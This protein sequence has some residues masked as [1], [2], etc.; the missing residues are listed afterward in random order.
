MLTI[1]MG[2]LLG[3]LIGAGC[4]WF[5][6]PMPSPPTL[7]GTLLVVARTVG[8]TFTDRFLAKRVS[9]TKHLCG[10]PTAASSEQERLQIVRREPSCHPS[11]E[12]GL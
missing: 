2:L 8:Y 5:E 4:R 1:V 9:T 7:V 11:N 3:L 12:L 10:S 6:I